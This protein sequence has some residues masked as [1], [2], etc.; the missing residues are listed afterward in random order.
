MISYC[1]EMRP[2]LRVKAK[3]QDKI[4]EQLVKNYD[5]LLMDEPSAFDLDYA[6]FINSVKTTLFF[7]A[8]INE[9]NEDYLLETYDIR[10]GEIRMKIE[11]ADWLL[12]SSAELSKVSNFSNELIREL[13]K[14]RTRVKAG[15]KE[16]LL[17]LLK[18]KGIG[19]VRARKLINNGLK[20]LGDLKKID[21]TSLSQIL[22][23]TLAVDVKKQLGEE[24]KEI[25]KM[26]R[27][28]QLS[29]N[30]F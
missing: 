29:L 25:P 2:Q 9:D 1:L 4:Q 20:D 24:V 5:L 8:W 30:K 19:R 17:V 21:L 27:K 26:T 3:E 10:P 13:Y 18:L 15:V 22:G 12:Y 7:E 16:E 28:G 11:I 23:V 6:Q 14:L